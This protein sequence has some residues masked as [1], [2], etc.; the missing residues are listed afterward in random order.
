MRTHKALP[1][2]LKPF[3]ISCASILLFL[4]AFGS[5]F[6]VDKQKKDRAAAIKGAMRSLQIALESYATDTGGSYHTN[7]KDSKPELTKDF[8]SA[9][10]KQ[11]YDIVELKHINAPELRTWLEDNA[12]DAFKPNLLMYFKFGNCGSY[13][14]M[15]TDANG[16][17][18]TGV[19]GSPLIMSNQ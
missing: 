18:V 7:V 15:G 10:G 16:R 8:L 6:L 17:I 9:Y 1:K 4:L 14:V 19:G 2:Y 12:G 11:R 5:Q 13:A 3:R